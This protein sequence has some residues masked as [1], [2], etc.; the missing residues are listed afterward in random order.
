[1]EPVRSTDYFAVIP[2]AKSS[3]RVI[4]KPI[5][6]EAFHQRAAVDLF[7]LGLIVTTTIFVATV[8]IG[9]ST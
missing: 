1:M 5:S 4:P 6:D 9:W 8:I 2:G 3:D 7:L